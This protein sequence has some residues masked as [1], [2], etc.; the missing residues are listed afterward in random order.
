MREIRYLDVYNNVPQIGHCHPHVVKAIAKQARKLNTSTRY[1]H[2]LILELAER[3]TSR[4][5]EPL[6]VCM[7]VCTGTEANELAWRMAKLVSGNDGALITGHS[8]HGN[9]DAII[10]FSS[11][12]VPHDKLP[13]H[14]A[15]L[16]RPTL[17]HHFPRTGFWPKAG[18]QVL[19][20]TGP[21]TGDADLRLGFHQ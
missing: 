20:G 4:L 8:Y 9:S 10:G 2:G 5:P 15:T 19:G 11:E 18:H 6:S 14:V 1:L 16:L 17:Q 13:T 7:F 21:S 12:E 3:I